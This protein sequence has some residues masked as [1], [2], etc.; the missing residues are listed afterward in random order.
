MVF[1]VLH[2][3]SVLEPLLHVAHG[4]AAPCA[5]TMRCGHTSWGPAQAGIVSWV[6]LNASHVY[7]IVALVCVRALCGSV[8]FNCKVTIHAHAQWLNTGAYNPWIQVK[9]PGVSVISHG[10]VTGLHYV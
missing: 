8:C 4:C 9:S 2:F 6:E 5:R 1:A 3:M 10:Q 7:G